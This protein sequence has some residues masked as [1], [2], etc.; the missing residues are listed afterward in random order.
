MARFNSANIRQSKLSV[1]RTLSRFLTRRLHSSC[2]AQWPTSTGLRFFISGALAFSVLLWSSRTGANPEGGQVVAGGATINLTAPSRIDVIQQTGKAIIDWRSFN[3]NS[4]EH[5]NFQQPSAS[6]VALNRV[7][8]GVSSNIN[9]LLTANGQLFLINP[10]GVVFGNGARVNVGSLVATTADIRNE[11]FLAGRYR[12]DKASDN[13]NAG[14]INRGVIHVA[15]GGAVVLAA[16]WVRNE[17]LI[18]ARL[19]QVALAGAKTFTLDFNGDGLLQFDVGSAVGEWPRGAD[20]IPVNALVS[21]PGTI[22]AD[23]GVV[24]LTARAASDVVDRV[25]NMDGLVQARAVSVKGGTIILS[26]GD[27]GI[28][29]V[30]GTLDASGLKAEQVGGTVKLLGEKVGLF[31]GARVDA[32]GSAG[33]GVVLVGGNFQGKGPEPN[34]KRTYVDDNARIAADAIVK[35][36]GGKVI[37][38]ADE[39]TGFF[40]HISARGGSK[41]GDGGFVEVSGKDGLIFQGT[42]DLSAANG[43]VGTLLLDPENIN[44]VSEG[45]DDDQL[46]D[47]TILQRDGCTTPDCAGVTFNISAGTLENLSADANVILEATN[48]ININVD[49]LFLD[50]PPGL[51]VTFT[52]NGNFTVAFPGTPITTQGGNLTIEAANITGPAANP[53]LGPDVQTN[54]GGIKINGRNGVV[55]IGDVN[56]SSTTGAGGNIMITAAGNVSTGAIISS[57]PSRGG[58]INLTSTNGAIAF[59]ITSD[60]VSLNAINSFSTN[61]AGGNVKLEAATSLAVGG[62]DASGAPSGNITLQGN[63]VDLTGGPNSVIAPGANLL[64]QPAAPGQNILL[65]APS[66]SDLATL[67]LTTGDLAA[68]AAGFGSMTLGRI[69]GTGTIT[70]PGT[71]FDPPTTILSPGG[72]IVLGPGIQAPALTAAGAT[73]S[74]QDVTTTGNQSYTGAVTLNNSYSTGGGNFAVTG[75][76]ALGSNTIVTTAGGNIIFPNVTGGGNN[77]I[78]NAGTAGNIS[79]ASVTGVGALTTSQSASTTFSGE[80]TATTVNL[81][82]TQNLITFDGRLAA[83]TLNTTSQPY[84]VA[85]NGGGEIA[86]PT[87]F[88]NTGGVTL[89]NDATDVMTFAG[90]LNTR[91]GLTTTAGAVRTAGQPIA[92]GALTLNG[93]TTLDTTNG[94]QT[95][96]GAAINFDTIRAGN[97]QALTLRAGDAAIA[98]SDIGESAQLG[99]LNAAGATISLQDVTTTGDQSYTGAVT[100]NSSYNTRGGNFA[101]TGSSALGSA[102]TITTLNSIPGAAPGGNITFAGTIDG[103]QALTLQA[104]TGNV[105]FG[106]DVGAQTRLG[107][108]IVQGTAEAA[109]ATDITIGGRFVAGDVN[110]VYTGFLTSPQG[111]LDV[112]SLSVAP[113]AQGARVFGTVAGASGRNAAPLVTGASADPD[114][115]INGCVIGIP[116][117]SDLVLPPPAQPRSNPPEVPPGDP[118]TFKP[119]AF[120]PVVVVRPPEDTSLDDPSTTQFSNFGNEELWTGKDKSK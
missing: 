24:A 12:F 27:E 72:A 50:S 100:F 79:A 16:P 104:G 85:L 65:G 93:P 97:N 61:G 3:I 67:D 13:P 62:I 1:R 73:I 46:D 120:P 91:A 22:L 59:N 29:G 37:V 95:N 52:A 21:N 109:G 111:S 33:G 28:V 76:A 14:V 35:G 75:S 53:L 101:V 26:G 32:S 17:G 102:T 39:L 119:L 15:D 6:A 60:D 34:A 41:S 115:T 44:I 31:D 55:N 19:G 99:S 4:L 20:G 43:K 90:G 40:G 81:V 7:G 92:M 87:A 84:G 36:D 94:G 63:E 47:G 80:V 96:T 5:T 117:F 9:G 77:L 112:S 68:L 118:A 11:D 23:G 45:G 18:Q 113:D 51:S 30:S 49:E 42:V 98:L 70:V 106:G 82:D 71:N 88:A 66:D 83:T 116:C 108:T 2:S 48:N 56:S 58:D 74:L 69:D 38:W 89:G 10:N 8:G 107:S 25:I 64:F 86:T 114:F 54:G 103:A 57:G 110:F 78:L 105:F